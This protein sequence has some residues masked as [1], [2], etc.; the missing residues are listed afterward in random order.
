MFVLHIYNS[1]LQVKTPLHMSLE[2]LS[3]K[4]FREVCISFLLQLDLHFH[5]SNLN[6]S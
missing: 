2:F 4:W 1:N 5:K 3:Y 6:M